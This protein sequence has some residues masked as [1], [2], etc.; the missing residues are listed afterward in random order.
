MALAGSSSAENRLG[1][2]L[3]KRGRITRDDYDTACKLMATSGLRFGTAL[4][5]LGIIKLEDLKPLVVQHVLRLIYS[6]FDW[7]LGDFV[8][9]HGMKLENEVMLS[10][11]TADVIFAGIRHLKNRDLID[12]WLGDCDRKGLQNFAVFDET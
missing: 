5:T 4:T 1:E 2:W 8:F 7:D 12:K 9:E 6:T 10:L 3:V 11:S